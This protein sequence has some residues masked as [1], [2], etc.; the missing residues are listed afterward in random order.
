MTR[1]STW[2]T[3]LL[4]AA[5]ILTADVPAHAAPVFYFYDGVMLDNDNT[6][7]VGFVAGSAF[8]AVFKFDDEDY[9]QTVALAGGTSEHQYLRGVL[10]GQTGPDPGDAEPTNPP[11]GVGLVQVSFDLDNNSAVETTFYRTSADKNGDMVPDGAPTTNGRVEL[12][13]NLLGG[14]PPNNWDWFKWKGSAFSKD[15]SII[16]V[17]G[18]GWID[19]Y[20]AGADTTPPSNALMTSIQTQLFNNGGLGILIGIGGGGTFFGDP[21]AKITSFRVSS[22]VPEPTS[23]LLL[24]IA[25]AMCLPSSHLRRTRRR[26][27][28]V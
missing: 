21:G 27:A 22:V 19:L 4:G 23:L 7:Q 14:A 13:D 6:G 3:C 11:Y 26:P 17:P 15:I 8:S 28:N 24:G 18:A 12:N 1:N 5:L 2:V 20:P 10:P 9:L 16:G 25:T